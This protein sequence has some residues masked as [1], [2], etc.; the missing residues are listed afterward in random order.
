VCNASIIIRAMNTPCG[1]FIALMMMMEAV[2][3]SKMSVYFNETA[4]RYIPESCHL[5]METSLYSHSQGAAYY[6]S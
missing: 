2:C 5:Q 1:L 3:T 6:G 4:W